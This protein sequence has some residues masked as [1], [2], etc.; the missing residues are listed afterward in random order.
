MAA[1]KEKLIENEDFTRCVV[2]N[3]K[4]NYLV[5]FK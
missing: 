3:V 2:V 5:R 1:K 4:N